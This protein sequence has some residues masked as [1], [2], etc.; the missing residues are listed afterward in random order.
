MNP[1]LWLYP[2]AAGLVLSTAAPSFAATYYVAQNSKTKA[3]RVTER[4]PNGSTMTQVGNDTYK[5]RADARAAMKNDSD[6]MK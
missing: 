5:T 3:C 6:C 2:L 4:K 1:K